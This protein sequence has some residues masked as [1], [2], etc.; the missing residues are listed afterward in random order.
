[1]TMINDRPIPLATKPRVE[2]PRVDPRA[3]PYG[4][5]GAA[6]QLFYLRDKEI[7]LDGPAGT[8]KTRGIL[9]KINLCLLKYPGS[10]G[11]IARK[12][13][14]SMTESVL[15]TLEKVLPVNSEL[16]PSTT[17]TLRRIRQNYEYPNASSLV[18][19]G[20]DNV[21]RIMSTEYDIIGVFEGTE[22]TESEWETLLSRLRNFVMPYQQGIID[23]NPGPPSH[24]LNRRPGSGK[25]TR[26]LS[27][28]E[29]NP[30]LFDNKGI[31]T[32]EGTGYLEI[33]DHLTGPR[34]L[35]LR[36][37]KWVAAEGLVYKEYDATIHL[38]QPFKIPD[39]WRR[40]RV[41]D[42]GYTNPFVCQWWAIDNDGRMYM[43][44]EVYM[45]GRIVEDHA[46]G[47]LNLDTG[48]R[49]G[50]IVAWSEGE[51]IEES[52]ADHDLEDRQTLDRHHV[53]TVPAYKD[54]ERGIQ[55]VVSRLKVAGDGKPRLFVF[56]DSLI[57]RDNKLEDQKL[58]M[59]TA[60]EFDGY[61]MAP[62]QDKHNQKEVPVDKD[63]HGMDAMRYAVAYVDDLR[64]VEFEIV[65]SLDR[66]IASV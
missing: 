2:K 17:D 11:L 27:K 42:F 36:L 31:L 25:M 12:T 40:I 7:L 61:I 52:I 28:H 58:P 43:Y 33:L 20:L 60:E 8:G 4:P 41:I 10:R 38:I 30:V 1:M 24:W 37:G 45:S 21:D 22:L 62:P 14:A 59:C 53:Y 9:E 26:L 46:M 57:E 63:N 48:K 66:P 29:D 3:K 64:N 13:R 50:G 35:R 32:K 47:E 51:N 54:I 18:V 6:K 56:R 23:C 15:V 44:K 5:R 49:Q 19:A 16:Y 65:G 55:A 39:S 34:Y